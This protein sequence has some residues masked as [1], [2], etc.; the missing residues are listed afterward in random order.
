MKKS[1]SNKEI[2][3]CVYNRSDDKE[4]YN[5]VRHNM[6]GAK[7]ATMKEVLKTEHYWAEKD[8]EV[9]CVI[10]RKMLNLGDL[11]PIK[12]KYLDK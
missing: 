12:I 9:F 11:E 3:D 1:V 10:V 6:E 2:M 7:M 8:W 4:L 5:K